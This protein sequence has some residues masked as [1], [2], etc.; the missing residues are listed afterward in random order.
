[1]VGAWDDVQSIVASSNVATA[2]LAIARL[3][4]AMRSRD[5]TA[6]SSSLTDARL[7]LG[8]PIVAAGANNYRRSYEAMLDLHL[9]YELE[10]IY[11]AI[12]SLP[13]QSGGVTPVLAGLS[14]VLST[15]L[16]TTLPTF[17]T[18]EPILSMRRTAFALMCVS[19]SS[20]YIRC[21]SS[22]E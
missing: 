7:I 1:M 10:T 16:D 6:I 5:S 21:L 17:R 9:T 18:R 14:E 3:L 2:Q 19:Y 4:L 8:G 13:Q 22:P 12:S 20:R 15:R 11:T